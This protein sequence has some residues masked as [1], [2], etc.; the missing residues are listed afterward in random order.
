MFFFLLPFAYL[1]KSF[2]VEDSSFKG[3]VRQIMSRGY[4]LM[5]KIPLNL[6]NRL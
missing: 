4:I 2:R 3:K 6:F 5:Y 1:K